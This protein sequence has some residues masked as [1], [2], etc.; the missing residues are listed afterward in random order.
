M[1]KICRKHQKKDTK[2]LLTFF[3]EA[4]TNFIKFMPKL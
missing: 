4:Q 2:T 1:V 3:L